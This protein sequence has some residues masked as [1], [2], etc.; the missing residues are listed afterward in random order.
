MEIYEGEVNLETDIWT[1]KNE[2]KNTQRDTV[3]VKANRKEEE[4][5]LL[6]KCDGKEWMKR[7]R[8]NIRRKR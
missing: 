2:N 8:R 4:E 5:E 7:S 3:L 1:H 6:K